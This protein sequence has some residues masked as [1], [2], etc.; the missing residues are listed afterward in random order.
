ME[1]WLQRRKTMKQAIQRT[2]KVFTPESKTSDP[3][4]TGDISQGQLEMEQ[5]LGLGPDT[6]LPA[7]SKDRQPRPHPDNTACSS[8]KHEKGLPASR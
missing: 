6:N 1:R 7:P 2:G 5:D 3:Q 4:S 8:M